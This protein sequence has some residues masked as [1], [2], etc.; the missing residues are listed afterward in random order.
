MDKLPE[1]MV[2]EVK[3]ALEKSQAGEI[4]SEYNFDD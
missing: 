2:P 4:Y 1:N 3:Q